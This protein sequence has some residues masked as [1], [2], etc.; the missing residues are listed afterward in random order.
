MRRLSRAEVLAAEPVF[1]LTVYWA[2]RVFR[3]AAEPVR[4]SSDEG[5]LRFVGGLNLAAFSD[6][7]P[8]AGVVQDGG[9][10]TLETVFPVNVAAEYFKGRPLELASCEVSMMLRTNGVID[11]AWEGRILLLVGTATAVQFG[12]P[13][14]DVGWA[15][16]TVSAHSY[17][18]ATPLI[19]PAWRITPSTMPNHDDSDAGSLTGTPYPIVFGDPGGG[20]SY[21]GSPAYLVDDRGANQKI[22]L[23]VGHVEAAN[24]VVWDADGARNNSIPVAHATDGNGVLYAYGNI[25][26]AA[27]IDRNSSAYWVS[28]GG[29][30]GGLSSPYGSGALTY[31]DE[32]IRYAFDR[33]S[34][35]AEAGAWEALAPV[36]R[37]FRFSGYVNDASITAW[38]W[39][40]DEVLEHLPIRVRIGAEG[41]YPVSL[42]HLLPVA[43]LPAIQVGDAW[44]VE[45]SS[46]FEVTTAIRDVINAFGLDY[47]LNARENKTTAAIYTT[48][49][50]GDESRERIA[51]AEIS[52]ATYGERRGPSTAAAF[53]KDDATARQIMRAKLESSGYLSMSVLLLA[54]PAYGWLHVGDQIGLSMDRYGLSAQRATVVSKRW[55][56]A[57]S[58]WSFE[59]SLSLTALDHNLP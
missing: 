8:R 32:M 34:T 45:Q 15:A 50:T 47:A 52:Q 29:G 12:W 22:L 46:P 31:A 2:G 23:S 4:I 48:A 40:R 25:A 7:I 58:R 28:W 39:L 26:G 20:A 37:R 14:R 53:V 54:R 3:F 17:D 1:F 27:T 55:D 30:A 16:F 56:R 59:V 11:G 33:M 42:L 18:D 13:A 6:A 38:T 36:L 44:G 24:V 43:A 41:A 57:L 9:E 51:A 5:T 19:D 35:K 10:A 49:D 21:P